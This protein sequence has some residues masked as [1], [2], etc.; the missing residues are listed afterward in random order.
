MLRPARG[1]RCAPTLRAT[2]RVARLSVLAAGGKGVGVA[3][4]SAASDHPWTAPSF[5]DRTAPV[6]NSRCGGTP[7][8]AHGARG[9]LVG[10][11]GDEG[12][13]GRIVDGDVEVVVPEPEVIP[14]RQAEHPVAAAVRDP[15]KALHVDVEELARLLADVADGRASEPVGVGEPAVAVPAEDAVHG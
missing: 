6:R 8:E 15:A 2:N 10:S 1:L 3:T 13:P 4:P 7:H 14:G 11:D 12:D 9:L 5:Q